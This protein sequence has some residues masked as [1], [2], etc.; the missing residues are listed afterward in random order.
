MPSHTFL[1]FTLA[2]A[3]ALTFTSCEVAPGGMPM[4]GGYGQTSVGYGGRPDY[5]P[6]PRPDY[7]PPPSRYNGGGNG[8]Y[9]Y[10][11]RPDYGPSHSSYPYRQ[12]PRYQQGYPSYPQ[13]QSQSSSSSAKTRAYDAG[14][15]LGRDDFDHKRSKHMDRHKGKFDSI[16]H[17]SFRDGYEAGY[18]HERRR[19]TRR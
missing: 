7:G 4:G 5:G 8:G 15:R 3:A 9:G 14:F 2:A 12:D 6:A 16:T 10:G 11:N 13:Q 1:T 19:D 18:D 17:D